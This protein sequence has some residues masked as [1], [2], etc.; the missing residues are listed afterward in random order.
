MGKTR[1]EASRAERKAKKRAAEDAIP[2]VPGSWTAAEAEVE[3]SSPTKK[4]SKKRK[5]D[6]DEDDGIGKDEKE[7]KKE[8]KKRRKEAEASEAANGEVSVEKKENK[9]KKEKKSNGEDDEAPVDLDTNMADKPEDDA[10]K[11]SK[12]ERKAERK[13][14]EAA[15]AAAN[16]T[17]SGKAAEVTVASPKINGSKLKSADETEPGDE[18]KSKKNNRNREKKR[19]GVNG[20]E[21]TNGEADDASSKA[22]RFIVFVGQLPFTATKESVEKHFASIKPKSVRVP[23]EKGTAGKAKGYAFVEFDGYDHMKTCLKLFHHSS[24]NDG[25]SAPRDINV[26]LTAGG[27][28]NTKERKGKIE[29]KNQK[30]DE[31]RIRRRQEE[32]KA[33]L[34]KRAEGEKKDL[35]DESAIHPSRRG[36]VPVMK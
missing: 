35:I 14:K 26:N 34:T 2:D 30:L 27:G 11:K 16:R 7:S 4:D 20:T 19:K 31:E 3:A 22:A 28:G 18:K 8:R 17:G 5:R 21:A 12:K 6:G 23:T 15:E 1:T 33:K 10:P 9:A 25:I 36:R 24:F 13:A 32:E 29:E